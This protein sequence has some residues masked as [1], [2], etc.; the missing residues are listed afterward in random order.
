MDEAELLLKQIRT[1]FPDQVGQHREFLNNAYREV[2]RNK[3]MHDWTM[4]QYYDGRREFA[5]AAFYYKQVTQKYDD[6]NLA[7]EARTRL[8]QLGDEPAKPSQK[9]PGLA[10]LFPSRDRDKPLVATS[11]ENTE[12]R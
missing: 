12:L 11:Q 1:Q 2:R 4:A 9:R 10:R 8:A 3:A 5:A 7:D 6:T